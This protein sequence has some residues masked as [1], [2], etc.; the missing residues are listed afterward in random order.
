MSL[1]RFCGAAIAGSA[2]FAG[3]L[4]ASPA[5]AATAAP[6]P[7]VSPVATPSASPVPTPTP[8]PTPQCDTTLVAGTGWLGGTGV[9]VYRNSGCG[10]R[11]CVELAAR[12]YTAKGWGKVWAGRNGGAQYIP[13]GSPGLE[14]HPN[15]TSYVPVPGDLVIEGLG[16]A[17]DPWGHV[18]VV[19]YVDAAGIHAVE[20]NASFAGRKTYPFDGNTATGAYRAR[21]VRGFMHSPANGGAQR[22]ATTLAQRPAPPGTPVNTT[23]AA[24]TRLASIS[25]R[26]P[27][28]PAP[29][30]YEVAIR[31]RNR[32]TKLWQGW[33]VV[34]IGPGATVMSWS[35]LPASVLYQLKVRAGNEVGYGPWSS[36]FAVTPAK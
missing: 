35:G 13:E 34:R 28:G 21:V 33:H 36:I 24:G 7:G 20:Q 11:Q 30:A 4:V 19:D 15:S 2:L 1:T 12:L 9:N 25:W 22:P 18:S 6:D 31:K 23:P 14:F 26:K 32:M 10:W 3:I 27:A 16:G 29:T 17:G 5:A 8:S